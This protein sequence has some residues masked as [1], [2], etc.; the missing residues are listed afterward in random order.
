MKP[1]VTSLSGLAL[2]L[3]VEKNLTRVSQKYR[4]V[5]L[6]LQASSTLV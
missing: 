4:L 6:A 1:Y 5:Y 2:R 3:T